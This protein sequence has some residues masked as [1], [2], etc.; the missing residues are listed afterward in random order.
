MFTKKTPPRASLRTLPREVGTDGLHRFFV[1]VLT[2]R[3]CRTMALKD[4]P[5]SSKPA[6]YTVQ[7]H[8]TAKTK[9]RADPTTHSA[10]LS[11]IKH[12]AVLGVTRLLAW[13][14]LGV[15]GVAICFVMF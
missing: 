7:A 10:D 9:A 14:V 11:D 4:G 15:L 12:R 1:F 3:D 6:I 8:Q 5:V 2:A 13:M